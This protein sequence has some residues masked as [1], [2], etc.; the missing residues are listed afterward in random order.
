[1]SDHDS[2]SDSRWRP[3]IR[4]ATRACATAITLRRANLQDVATTLNKGVAMRSLLG[5]QPRGK[6]ERP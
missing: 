5:S 6:E 4:H 2:Y 3:R 1:M